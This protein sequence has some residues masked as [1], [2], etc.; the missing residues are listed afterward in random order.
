MEDR[1]MRRKERM[2]SDEV[3]K[4]ILNCGD[5]GILSLITDDN[6]AY[7]VP[8]NYVVRNNKILCH[9]AKDGKKL[10]C[11]EHNPNVCFTVIGGALVSPKEFT[12][13][14][15]S[16]MVFGKASIIH[17]KAELREAMI[18][19]CTKYSKEVMDKA[20]EVTDKSIDQFVFISI[21]IENISGKG[22][23]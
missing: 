4:D 10:K 13:K 14:Y 22:N 3:A 6:K 23:Y 21:D 18:Q 11:I 12:T 16:V 17:D 2:L 19:L 5:H 9:C 7:G 20:I 1:E 8:L 15:R